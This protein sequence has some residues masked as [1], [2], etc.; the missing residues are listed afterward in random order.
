MGQTPA[1]IFALAATLFIVLVPRTTPPRSFAALIVAVVWS[2][3]AVPGVLAAE[4]KPTV[5]TPLSF[6]ATREICFCFIRR[7]ADFSPE[8]A[9]FDMTGND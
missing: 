3:V 7:K 8:N 9:G 1:A 6:R 4:V 2:F 5:D